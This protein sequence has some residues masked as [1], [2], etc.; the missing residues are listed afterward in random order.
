VGWRADGPVVSLAEGGT[1]FPKRT[2]LSLPWLRFDGPDVRG[3]AAGLGTS[4]V[5]FVAVCQC[6][7][8]K[9]NRSP[10]ILLKQKLRSSQGVNCC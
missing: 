10:F 9:G 5:V 8:L 7:D 3:S 6:R 2:A 1:F 4:F